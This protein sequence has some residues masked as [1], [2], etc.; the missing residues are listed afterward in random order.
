MKVTD[1]FN[2]SA[3]EKLATLLIITLAARLSVISINQFEKLSFHEG[4]KLSFA[5]RVKSE[6][7]NP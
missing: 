6:L 7:V 4:F 5:A 3:N 2:F 1:M